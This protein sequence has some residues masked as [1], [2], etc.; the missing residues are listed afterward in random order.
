MT[1]HYAKDLAGLL[2]VRGREMRD[3][4]RPIDYAIEHR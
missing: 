2:D 4:D 3:Y 1:S